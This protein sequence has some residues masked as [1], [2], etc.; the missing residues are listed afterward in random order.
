MFEISFITFGDDLDLDHPKGCQ[1]N[2]SEILG[3]IQNVRSFLE[4]MVTFFQYADFLSSIV[5]E[6]WQSEF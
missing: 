6:K 2:L 3:Q 4:I 5:R 1:K